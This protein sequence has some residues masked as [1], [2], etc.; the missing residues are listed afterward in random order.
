[1]S[2]NPVALGVLGRP[3]SPRRPFDA[4]DELDPVPLAVVLGVL[5]DFTSLMRGMAV[6]LSSGGLGHALLSWS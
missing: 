5:G 3:R 6:L 1:M 4:A 2:L